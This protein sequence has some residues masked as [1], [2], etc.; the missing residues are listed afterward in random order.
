MKKITILLLIFGIHFAWGDSMHV[1]EFT[2]VGR[3]E[4]HGDALRVIR[5]L[6]KDVLPGM[7]Q[8][9]QLEKNLAAL[10]KGDE[11]V[12]KGHVAYEMFSIEGQTHQRPILVI[13]SIRPISLE[14]LGKIDGTLIPETFKVKTQKTYMPLAMPVTTEVASALTLTTSMLLL[15][16]L[17][18]T[19]NDPQISKDINTGMII[20]AG[21]MAT[22]IFIYDQ[23]S[24]NRIKGA[25]K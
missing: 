21:V 8:D 13:Q 22:G 2:I 7:L 25:Q 15:Q 17:T 14:E 5:S 24:G 11:V 1:E 20:F 4:G 19:S 18:A 10:Q 16:S 3:I 12:I 6:E 9:K 23:I